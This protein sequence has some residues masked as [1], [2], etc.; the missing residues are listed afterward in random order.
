MRVSK[1]LNA[2]A[3]AGC[4]RAAAFFD[5]DNTLIAGS[6]LFHLG[7]G[8]FRRGMF[9]PLAAFRFAVAHYRFRLM[10]SESV[11]APALWGGFAASFVKGAE[12]AE[13]VRIGRKIIEES[14]KP[15]IRP[16][17]LKMAQ[18]HLAARDEAWIVTASPQEL[19]HIL[20]TGLGFTGGLGTRAEVIDG[21]YTGQ[22]SG[23]ILHG[24]RKA[25]AIE[26]LAM[27]RGLNLAAS[28]A[29]GD[30]IHDLPMLQAV[31]FPNAVTPD[32]KLARTARQRGWPIHEYGFHRRIFKRP[33]SR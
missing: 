3:S 17:V 32:R 27:E 4:L 31:G 29:Y 23:G 12:V 16:S 25:I 19:S 14:I 13:L 10:R 20:A 26:E 33:A 24:P 11:G 22:I 30:S 15:A 28:S 9:S 6:S 8:G 2:D 1:M 21:R 18:K 5:L 7:W